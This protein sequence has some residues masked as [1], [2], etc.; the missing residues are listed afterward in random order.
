MITVNAM[1]G[2]NSTVCEFEFK[3]LSTDT[4]PTGK[5]GSATNAQGS[6]IGGKTIGENSLFLELDTGDLYYYAGG[7]WKKAGG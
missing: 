3:G 4:K 5:F 6:E 7:E 2:A 1:L